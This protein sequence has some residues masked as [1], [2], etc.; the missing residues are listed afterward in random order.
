NGK[1]GP[2]IA[3]L[4][5][6]HVT[7]WLSAYCEGVLPA[8]QASSVAAHVLACPRC[9]RDLAQ[10]RVG[11]RLAARLRP[12]AGSPPGAGPSWSELAPLL[13][14]PEAAR[15]RIPVWRWAPALA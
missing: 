3:G 1:G 10:V 6:R 12:D 13:A 14:A 7:R 11:A 5:T 4:F 8:A 2:V 9:N 15:P